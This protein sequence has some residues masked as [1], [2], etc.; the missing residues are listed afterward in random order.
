MFRLRNEYVF[1]QRY[2]ANINKWFALIM[3]EIGGTR[4]MHYNILLIRGS[5]QKKNPIIVNL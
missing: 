3:Q 5:Y 2:E 4:G 1:F